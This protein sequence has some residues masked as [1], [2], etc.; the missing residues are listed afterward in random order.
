MEQIINE[1]E[2]V[3]KIIAD[4]K[5]RTAITSESHYWFF[6]VYFSHYVKYPTAQFQRE[7]F[8]LTEQEEINNIVVVAFRSSAKSSIMT[9]SYPIWSILGKQKKKFVVILGQTQAKA[10]QHLINLKR[11]F[12]SNDLLRTDLGPFEERDEEWGSYSLVLP[13]YGAKIMAASSEQSIRG[14]RHGENRPDLII[15]DD[16]EDLV[17]VKTREG[18]DKIY[19]WLTGDVIPAGDKNTRL[20]IIGNLLHED[21]LLMRLKQN[22]SENKLNGIFRAYP[23]INSDGQ[24]LWPGKF[25]SM[26]EIEE[27]KRSTGND[28]AWQREYCLRIVPDTD[29][30]IK[31]EWVQYFNELPSDEDEKYR[32]T[33]TGVDLAISEKDSADFTAMVSAKV[34]GYGKDLK[35]YILPEIVNIKAEFPKVIERIKELLKHLGGG[36]PSGAYVESNAYQAAVSQYLAFQNYPITGVISRGDKRSRAISITHLIQNGTIRFPKHGAEQLIEQLVYFGVEKHDDLVDAFVLLI[37]KI[38]EDS[39][40]RVTPEIFWA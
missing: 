4:R 2:L 26:T 1:N 5:I 39:Y 10:R 38:L 7:M 16:V 33:K 13:K 6:N 12:E 17:S 27:L 30:I 8:S 28:I 23:L 22:I 29:Q 32:Y 34:F 25:A 35:I 14:L 3:D 40:E 37:N 18:R 36:R 9:L 11:E 21:S 19:D 31:P 15:C 24:I 20:I